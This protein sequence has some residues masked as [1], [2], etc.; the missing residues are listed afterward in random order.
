MVLA[1]NPGQAAEALEGLA[2]RL[3][4]TG[5]TLK[6]SKGATADLAAGRP[7]EWLGYEIRKEPGGVAAR[8]TET[9]WEKLEE[10][11][12]GA[13]DKPDAPVRALETIEG[14]IDQAG[15]CYP[16]HDTN[17]TCERVERI[18]RRYAFE[19]VPPRDELRTTWAKANARWKTRGGSSGARV[20]TRCDRQVRRPIRHR[21]R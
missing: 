3:R 11:L 19:E 20:T 6:A 5:M 1:G 14:W 21:P 13:H 12:A 17:E 8:L 18:A 10:A 15:P 2:D 9:S 16:N 7:V 4:P